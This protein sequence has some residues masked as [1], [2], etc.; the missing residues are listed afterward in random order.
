L[1]LSGLIFPG[2]Q[3]KENW[4]LVDRGLER[5]KEF[6]TVIDS[7]MKSGYQMKSLTSGFPEL[8]DSLPDSHKINYWS[9]L[10]ELETQPVQQAVVLSY[11]YAEG[12]KGRRIKLPDNVRWLTKVPDSTEF[13]LYAMRSSMD[14]L[15]VRIGK[16]RPEKTI[17]YFKNISDKQTKR[18]GSNESDTVSAESRSIISVTIFSDDSFEQ[19]KKVMIAALQAVDKIH[20]DSIVIRTYP[21]ATYKPDVKSTWIIVLAEKPLPIEN[22]NSITFNNSLPTEDLFI[23]AL[24]KTDY[25]AWILT[26]RLS[27]G[28]ALQK[29]LAV[30]LSYILMPEEK[31]AHRATQFDKRTLADNV[32]WS[33]RNLSRTTGRVT[34]ILVSQRY[35][36]VL[37]LA[38]LVIERWLSFKRSQ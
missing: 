6:S 14:S 38:F 30:A 29:N 17:Y 9:I 27:Q 35:L 26:Q 13:T 32:M 34:D 3:K 21:A 23:Q 19:D 2:L 4:L 10:T 33:A 20:P 22:G 15:A 12:F 37:F 11:N 31:Y 16:T 36:V 24:N 25:A 8:S 1:L 5:E 28:I 18:L 7:L